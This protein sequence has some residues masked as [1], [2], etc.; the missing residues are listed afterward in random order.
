MHLVLYSVWGNNKI[1]LKILWINLT[2]I[3][4]VEFFRVD[5]TAPFTDED[6]EVSYSF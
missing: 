2:K 3:G 4:A 5:S 6:E 1:F